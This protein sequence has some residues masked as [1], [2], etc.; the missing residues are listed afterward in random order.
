MRR[1]TPFAICLATVLMLAAPSWAWHDKGHKVTALI[2]FRS[3][4][5]AA[6]DRVVS[7]LRKHVAFTN[8]DWPG[9]VEAGTDPDASLFLFASVFPDDA[10]KPQPY[11][12]FHASDAHFIDIPLV[13]DRRDRHDPTIRIEDPYAPQ[14]L[15]KA[16]RGHLAT[17]KSASSSDADRAI[18]VSWLFHLAGDI[19]QPLHSVTL[20]NQKLKSG[21]RGGNSI[22]FAPALAAATRQANLHAYWDGLP[23]EDS[24]F[25]NVETKANELMMNLPA[26]GLDLTGDA[27]EEWMTE[28]F[29]FARSTVYAGLT[30]AGGMI[31]SLPAGYEDASKKV[32][33]RRLAQAGYR[34]ARLL[35][36]LFGTP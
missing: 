31:D 6:R 35:E 32:A 8:G 23:G 9:R 4:D 10:R 18:A 34:L 33:D 1:F 30:D 13:P 24:E 14:N 17:I 21:D 5:P 15:V 12:E 26:S 20:Y 29:G 25:A 16:F 3:M 28:S 19:H 7:L 11:H 22:R 2:A 27:V 36:D